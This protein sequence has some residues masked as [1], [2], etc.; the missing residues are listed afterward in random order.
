V[1]H[2]AAIIRELGQELYRRLANFTGHLGRTGARLGA[3]VEAYNAAVGS[4]ERQVLPQARRFTEL[5]VTADAPIAALETVDALARVPITTPASDDAAA[6]DTNVEVPATRRVNGASNAPVHAT[7]S[8]GG[9][10]TRDASGANGDSGAPGDTDA[11]DDSG[12]RDNPDPRGRPDA[13]GHSDSSGDFDA[14]LSAPGQ[15]DAR[16]T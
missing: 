13:R 3:A 9:A 7:T 10:D 16:I 1:A 8:G 5:G 6:A 11:R 15:S 2:N 14:D 4:L 12:T